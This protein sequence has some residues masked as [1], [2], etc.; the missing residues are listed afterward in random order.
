MNEIEQRHRGDHDRDLRRRGQRI[1]RVRQRAGGP[2][3][4]RPDGVH[5]GQEPGRRHGAPGGAR[6]HERCGIGRST[7]PRAAFGVADV[8]RDRPRRWRRA[9]RVVLRGARPVDL[10]QRSLRSQD[11]GRVGGD[12][13]DRV[14]PR[15]PDGDPCGGD[16]A[17][18]C[19]ASRWC[20][21]AADWCTASRSSNTSTRRSRSS[22]AMSWRSTG[23]GSVSGSTRVSSPGCSGSRIG[24]WPTS[25]PAE[26]DR[27]PPDR[28]NFGGSWL[29]PARRPV[30]RPA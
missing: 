17:C 26:S 24:S 14:P 13:G 5:D 15:A 21:R 30:A 20:G 19:G 16:R 29:R 7:V 3:L 1:R 10:D 8:G 12:R 6:R 22:Q 4:R 25:A 11:A 28:F 9:V 2:A 23:T 18:S 27:R